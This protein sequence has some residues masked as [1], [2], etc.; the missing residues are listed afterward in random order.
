MLIAAR[1]FTARLSFCL[2]RVVASGGR[3]AADATAQAPAGPT[4]SHDD[5]DDISATDPSQHVNQLRKH[6]ATVSG[7]QYEERRH[8]SQAAPGNA[9]FT[10]LSIGYAS[11][12]LAMAVNPQQVG[13]V[14]VGGVL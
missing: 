6:M 9:E 7:Q 13:L 14:G 1:R 12:A 4:K 11:V 5:H 3:A 2:A 10:G 8:G